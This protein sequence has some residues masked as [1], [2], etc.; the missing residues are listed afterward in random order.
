MKTPTPDDL[1]YMLEHENE[2]KVPGLIACSVVC[3]F[4]ASLAVVLRFVARYASKI[5]LRWSDWLI[6]IALVSLR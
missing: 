2:T 1:Q 3:V 6:L 5:K 4:A